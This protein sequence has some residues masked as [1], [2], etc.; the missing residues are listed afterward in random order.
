MVYDIVIHPRG[1][2]AQPRSAGGVHA[3]RT[4]DAL[5]RVL[6]AIRERDAGAL[7]EVARGA[8]PDIGGGER[9]APRARYYQAGG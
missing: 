9:G 3:A 5:E 8:I 6:A 7:D 4:L 1:S 2:V